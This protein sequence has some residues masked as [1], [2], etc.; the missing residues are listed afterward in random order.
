MHYFM[1]DVGWW[2]QCKPLYD[3]LENAKCLLLFKQQVAQRAVME[4]VD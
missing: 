4:W 1:S 2:L 3:K